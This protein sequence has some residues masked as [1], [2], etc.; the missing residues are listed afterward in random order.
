MTL[1]NNNNNYSLTLSEL[2]AVE[3]VTP[4]GAPYYLA[5]KEHT[6]KCR[7]VAG[8]P[9]ARLQWNWQGLGDAEDQWL[10]TE[11]S[12]NLP[13]YHWHNHNQEVWMTVQAR[14][15]GRYRCHASNALGSATAFADFI[16][17]GEFEQILLETWH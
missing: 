16:V 13:Y 17:T 7:L 2:P 9:Q 6:I 3:I 4:I 11:L 14:Q 12:H 1:I 10:A 15:S 8:V 5:N